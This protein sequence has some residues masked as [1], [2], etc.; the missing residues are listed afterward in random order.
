MLILTFTLCLLIAFTVLAVQ[1]V[2]RHG[3]DISVSIVSDTED[4]KN[5]VTISV[6][7][8][9]GSTLLFYENAEMCGKIEYLSDDGWVEYCDVSYTANNA[10]AVSSQYGGTFAEL[11]PGEDWKVSIPND[12]LADM[13]DGTYRIKMT[14]I[15]EKKYN[16][17]I[18]D[19][20]DE[21]DYELVNPPVSYDNSNGMTNVEMKPISESKSKNKFYGKEKF[22][23]ESFS[24]VYIET[25]EYTSPNGIVG[26]F[27][28]E[29][30]SE[31][32]DNSKAIISI[33]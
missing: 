26:E 16:S 22:L 7:N 33:D 25:F 6:L 27:N 8:T 11:Q 18:E 31:S 23:A 4:G 5:E 21:K 20:F 28:V 12:K 24:E 1:M 10:G 17:Y 15:T 13:K 29:E 3:D 19:A 2:L 14:Y 30:S 9:A 32:V